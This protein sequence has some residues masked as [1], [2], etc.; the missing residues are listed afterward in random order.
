MRKKLRWTDFTENNR[1]FTNIERALNN[2]QNSWHYD[3]IVSLINGKQLTQENKIQKYTERACGKILVG[4][5]WWPLKMAEKDEI[6]LPDTHV[7]GETGLRTKGTE[8]TKLGPW[9]QSPPTGQLLGSNG[10]PWNAVKLVPPLTKRVNT[11]LTRLAWEIRASAVSEFIWG[12][13]LIP[14]ARGRIL[15]TGSKGNQLAARENGQQQ[16]GTETTN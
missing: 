7:R 16:N 14:N 1:K 11:D 6:F 8:K 15:T 10:K 4:E 5:M 3:I 9:L 12:G 2:S 13:K